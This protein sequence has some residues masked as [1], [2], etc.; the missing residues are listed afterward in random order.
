MSLVAFLCLFV[1]VVVVFVLAGSALGAL[2]G[3]AG[4]LRAYSA[5]LIGSLLG[6]AIFTAATTLNAGPPVWLLI[7]GL[8]FAFLSRR[9]GPGRP[10]PE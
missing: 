4:P 2:F 9:G 10:W 3:Q 7:A 8:P 5:D 6:V 1:G